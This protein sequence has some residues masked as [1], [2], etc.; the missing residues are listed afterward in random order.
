MIDLKDFINES[1]LDDF[2]DIA[3]KTDDNPFSLILNSKSEKEFMEAIDDLCKLC[4]KIDIADANQ[5]KYKNSFFLS[6]THYMNGKPMGIVVDKMLKKSSKSILIRSVYNLTTGDDDTK[7]VYYANE[8]IDINYD[9]DINSKW[10]GNFG[11]YLLQ[12]LYVMPKYL[13]KF[14][15]D[16]I[17]KLRPSHELHYNLICGEKLSGERLIKKIS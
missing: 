13:E 15:L 8:K 14:Y 2:D 12:N 4:D 3:D 17:K 1:L 5:K 11:T 7:W 16:I 9:E 6:H 10:C